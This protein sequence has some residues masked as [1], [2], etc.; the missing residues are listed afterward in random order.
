MIRV[1]IDMLPMG[2]ESKAYN[3]GLAYITNDGSGTG[4]SGNYRIDLLGGFVGWN[5]SKR[6]WKT[7]L[8]E[9]FPRARLGVW[10]LFYRGLAACVSSRS[11]CTP[12]PGIG[13]APLSEV[14][15][16]GTPLGRAVYLLKTKDPDVTRTV[17]ARMIEAPF[18]TAEGQEVAVLIEKIVKA[19]MQEV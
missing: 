11:T 4:H 13:A 19:A 2:D 1:T 16:S 8:V 18:A 17:I 3:I 12:T 14:P 10:D 15:I 6:V 7:A 5:P 9:S